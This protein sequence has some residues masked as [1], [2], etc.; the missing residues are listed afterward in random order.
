MNKPKKLFKAIE[1][2][3]GLLNQRKIWDFDKQTKQDNPIQKQ[4]L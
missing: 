4:N 3:I 1:P 2:P